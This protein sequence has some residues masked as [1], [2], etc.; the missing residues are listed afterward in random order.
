MNTSLVEVS[1]VI[2]PV[3]NDGNGDGVV[4]PIESGLVI[5]SD[6]SFPFAAAT[7]SKALTPVA[8]RTLI[9]SRRE[10]G[11]FIALPPESSQFLNSRAV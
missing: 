2:S 10:I 9:K 11:S 7:G 4:D 5:A 1:E 3:V 6:E 8:P